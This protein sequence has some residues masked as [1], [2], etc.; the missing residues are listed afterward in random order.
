MDPITLDVP[1]LRKVVEWAEAEAARPIEE[2][3]WNQELWA[4]AGVEIERTCGTAFCVAGKLISDAD[5]ADSLNALS[6]VGCIQRGAELLGV[7][8]QDVWSQGRYDEPQGLFAPGNTIADVRAE[9]A[10][11]AR[12]YGE[13][14]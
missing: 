13:V 10:E 6:G 1:L 3:E 4:V 12:L 11:L 14:L 7:S 2:C 9:A 8:S 5:G